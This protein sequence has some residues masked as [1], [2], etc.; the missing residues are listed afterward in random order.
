MRLFFVYIFCIQTFFAVSQ[1]KKHFAD[2][3]KITSFSFM[4]LHGGTVI[5]KAQLD[6]FEDTLNFVLDTGSGG[7][8]LDSSTVD[9]LQIERTKTDRSIRGIA[10]MKTVD[11]VYKHSL[12]LKGLTVDSLDFH[13][14]NYDILTSAYGIKIDGI[15]GY[16]F[17][18]RYI[19]KLNYDNYTIEIFK[20][21]N[22][23][24]PAN[25]YVLHPNFTLL[26]VISTKITDNQQSNGNFI[27][28][29]GAGLNILLSDEYVEDS[30]IVSKKRK[31]FVTQAEGLG[32]K[33]IM[34]T[35]VV[36]KIAI[37]PYKFR[38]VPVYIFRDDYNVTGY[39]KM[40]GVIGND[41]LR[42]FNLIIN[43]PNKEI[44][45]KPNSHFFDDFDYSYTGLSLYQIDG[46]VRVQ[47]IVENSPAAKAGFQEDDIVFAVDNNF[48]QNIQAYKQAL[49]NA[50]NT[51]K[52]IVKRGVDIV[53][54]SLDIQHLMH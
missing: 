23:K 36:K 16:S 25:G 26:P 53:T 17:F 32:G 37:G 33:K 12:K 5:I 18:R 35:T 50:G 19:V 49:Q 29:T 51:I 13:V 6:N 15:I 39:P 31:Q 42:R 9:Y 4:M 43:Y 8:S 27:F 30:S 10:G 2:N 46:V 28:D 3:S 40:G 47:N 14:N 38:W 44:F 1:Q 24:Y 45:I 21:S 22:I 54:L 41:I 20:P 7:I 52:I 48:T 34:N 11:F